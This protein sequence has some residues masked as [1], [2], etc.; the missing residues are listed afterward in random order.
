MKA[1]MVVYDIPTTQ[2][3]NPYPSDLFR[4]YGVRVN[5]SC[6][7]VP[8]NRLPLAYLTYMRESRCSVHVVPFAEEAWG[9]I[10]ELAYQCLRT[11]SARIMGS[12]RKSLSR[13]EAKL[14][15]AQAHRDAES[16][17]KFMS[18]RKEVLRRARVHLKA[19]EEASIGFMLLGRMSESLTAVKNLIEAETDIDFVPRKALQQLTL[20]VAT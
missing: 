8:T 4:A 13:V 6:W 17:K 14:V 3:I 19:A 10:Q 11:E 2:I 15:L 20:A 1:S 9:E 7:V 16:E 18:H 5:L 12:L